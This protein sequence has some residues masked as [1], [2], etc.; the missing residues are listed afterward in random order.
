MDAERFAIVKGILVT[1]N[2]TPPADRAAY[3]DRACGG[4][5]AL[6]AEIESLLGNDTRSI[7]RTGGLTD[8]I[9]PIVAADRVA[10]GGRIGPYKLTGVLGEG[11]MGVVY[12]A[13]QTAPIQ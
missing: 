3:L 11:G 6:R 12:Q 4:D 8:R 7:L 13:E 2:S 5:A 1:L 10:V 9:A